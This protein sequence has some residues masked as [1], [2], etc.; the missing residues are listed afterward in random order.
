MLANGFSEFSFQNLFPAWL[1]QAPE[2]PPE[3][4]RLQSPQ[5]A[6]DRGLYVRVYDRGARVRGVVLRGAR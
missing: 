6:V 2:R 5:T 3:R 1:L 4:L